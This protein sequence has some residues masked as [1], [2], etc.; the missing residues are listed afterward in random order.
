MYLFKCYGNPL[1]KRNP[2]VWGKLFLRRCGKGWG[3]DSYLNEVPNV[4][5]TLATLNDF[6]RCIWRFSAFISQPSDEEIHLFSC[7]ENVSWDIKANEN[8]CNVA[9]L[10]KCNW[11]LLLFNRIFECYSSNEYQML[12]VFLFVIGIW[13]FYWRNAFVF[14]MGWI[15]LF[16]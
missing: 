15:S 2:L 10:L 3:W 9:K 6:L 8:E 13:K 1:A 7:E 12:W 14:S 5:F 4:E 11:N 16:K